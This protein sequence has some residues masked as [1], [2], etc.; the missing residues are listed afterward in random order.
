M[1]NLSAT[2]RPSFTNPEELLCSK[3]L[4]ADNIQLIPSK[5]VH[6]VISPNNSTDSKDIWVYDG[7]GKKRKESTLKLQFL[8]TVT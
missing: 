4:V 7:S 8:Q 2:E 5:C 3:G 1:R 6:N